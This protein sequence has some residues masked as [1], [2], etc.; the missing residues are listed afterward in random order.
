MHRHRHRR[1]GTPADTHA[2]THRHTAVSADQT[3]IQKCSLGHTDPDGCTGQAEVYKAGRGV[4]D[5][6][7]CTGH[8]ECHPYK[9]NP[10]SLDEKP[11]LCF[12]PRQYDRAYRGHR[13]PKHKL[14]LV[15]MPNTQLHI[16]RIAVL[17][18][19]AI[20]KVDKDIAGARPTSM[21]QHQRAPRQ[22]V[23]SRAPSRNLAAHCRS[24]M[25]PFRLRRPR[26]P[27]L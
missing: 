22:R 5:R 10:A 1:T 23:A 2:Y 19:F 21:H 3:E 24:R 18:S 4:Q 12:G 13:G 8:G 25:G 6:L 27:Q 9:I 7:R 11:H 16:L 17:R 26:L 15:R 14:K 20:V